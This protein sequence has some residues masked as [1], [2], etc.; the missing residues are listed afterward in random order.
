[1]PRPV[2]IAAFGV[3][4]NLAV[5]HAAWRFVGGHEDHIWEPTRR[6]VMPSGNE[7]LKRRRQGREDG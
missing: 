3:A 7:D 2:S 1:M 4:A 6:T 5:L